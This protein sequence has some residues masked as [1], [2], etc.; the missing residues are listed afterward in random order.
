M[1]ASLVSLISN[2]AE[3][4]VITDTA[5][6]LIVITGLGLLYKNVLKPMFARVQQ[7]PTMDEIKK[8]VKESSD[9]D[10]LNIEE[11]SKKLKE[12]ENKLNE[13]E[14][15]LKVE[16]ADH[17]QLKRDIEQIKTMLNQFQGHMMYNNHGSAFGN[18][19]LK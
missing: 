19:E 12:I 10:E 11:V 1:E 15:Y 14:D 16:Q 13:V 8:L 18:R 2:L 7:Q 9:K 17:A 4:G 6:I 3:A 5:L